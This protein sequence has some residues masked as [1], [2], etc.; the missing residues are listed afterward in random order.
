[1]N[2]DWAVSV[3]VTYARHTYDFNATGRGET[4]VAGKDMDSAPRLLGSVELQYNGGG[5][6]KF[7]LQWMSLD[8]YFL[9]AE[10]RFQYPGHSLLHFR[11]SFSL[12]P[13]TQLIFRL[14][15]I[16]D[17]AVADRADYAFGNY[18]YFPGRGRELFAEFRYTLAD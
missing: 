1:M 11:A 6:T 12:R 17:K 8:E 10:N 9:E 7:G 13:Q 3:D 5:R 4:F 18:R 2:S 15:N 16:T 14:N